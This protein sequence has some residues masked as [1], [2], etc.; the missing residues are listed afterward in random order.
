MLTRNFFLPTFSTFSRGQS[1]ISGHNPIHLALAV[2]DSVGGND[3][4]QTLLHGHQYM[5]PL[6]KL[7][8]ATLI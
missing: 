8:C 4:L 7:S 3:V 1:H 6:L 5:K 2:K